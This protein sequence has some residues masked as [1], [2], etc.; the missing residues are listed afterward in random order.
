M[1]ASLNPA[2]DTYCA[3]ARAYPQ[4]WRLIAGLITAGLIYLAFVLAV[5]FLPARSGVF[6]DAALGGNGTPLETSLVLLSFGGMGGGVVL[7]ARLFQKRGFP[8]LLGPDPRAILRSF[9][10]TFAIVGGLLAVWMG[11]GMMA[12]APVPNLLARTWLAW[13]PSSLVLLLV[14]T[15]S[16]ELVF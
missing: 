15:G 3:P 4:I 7:A 13:L 14:Q 6:I 5:V 10:V 8:S 2:F 16:E 9:F 12:R 1:F 11:D